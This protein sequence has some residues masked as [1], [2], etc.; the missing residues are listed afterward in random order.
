MIWEFLPAAG[1]GGVAK[2]GGRIQ[3]GEGFEHDA[4]C[5]TAGNCVNAARDPKEEDGKGGG[6]F[7]LLGV[8]EVALTVKEGLVTEHFGAA[9]V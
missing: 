2:G 4:K 5:A 9:L 8:R 7:L 3:G 1:V 6:F